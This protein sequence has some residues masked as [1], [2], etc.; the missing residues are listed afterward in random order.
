MGVFL[1][2]VSGWTE[3]H[4]NQRISI[5]RLQNLRRRRCLILQRT[6]CIMDTPTVQIGHNMWHAYVFY[7]CYGGHYGR[8][9]RWKTN[10][11]EIE[12]S[13]EEAS[14]RAF[15]YIKCIM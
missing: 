8:Y 11:E 10:I 14:S 13:R 15:F 1:W 2:L 7:R 6:L 3:R 5:G 9:Y 12:K 4:L